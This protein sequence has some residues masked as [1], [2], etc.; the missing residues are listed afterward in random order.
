MVIVLL[1]QVLISLI[2]HSDEDRRLNLYP[3][4]DD[5]SLID[6]ELKSPIDEQVLTKARKLVAL[7]VDQD[8]SS[9]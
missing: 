8:S 5:P 1:C 9:G 7:L 2:G 3:E 6:C 4:G